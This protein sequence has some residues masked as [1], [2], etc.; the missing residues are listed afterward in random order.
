MV[1]E[2]TQFI[3]DIVSNLRLQSFFQATDSDYLRKLHFLLILNTNLKITPL[4]ESDCNVGHVVGAIPGI[5]RR[6]YFLMTYRYNLLEFMNEVIE[7]GPFIMV[8][9]LLEVVREE[10]KFLPSH[11]R[12]NLLNAILQAV[13]IRIRK[14]DS[15]TAA[16]KI[17]EHFQMLLLHF[18]KPESDLEETSEQAH[19]EIVN[20]GYKF[21]SLISLLYEMTKIVYDQASKRESYPLYEIKVPDSLENLSAESGLKSK[22]Q[23]MQEC[24]DNV[25]YKSREL[26]EELNLNMFLIWYEIKVDERNLQSLIGE[27][28]YFL[29][30]LLEEKLQN[31][32]LPASTGELISMLQTIAVKPAVCDTNAEYLKKSI[33]KNDIFNNELLELVECYLKDSFFDP[34]VSI[35]FLRKFFDERSRSNIDHERV[36]KI[37]E[38]VM[39]KLD[40]RDI[41]A[42]L[43]DFLITN[44]PNH[45]LVKNGND[46]NYLMKQISVLYTNSGIEGE[47][48]EKAF[49]EKEE[50]RV[51]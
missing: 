4:L 2:N 22:S 10:I 34:E 26:M 5:S 32:L 35:H 3:D 18:K 36:R 15:D 51:R 44:G 7:F 1:S 16:N 41:S 12:F 39:R 42:L 47:E 49:I 40:V 24:Y 11:D 25:L 29:C 9:E 30:R 50:E 17:A 37:I 45:F 48:Q 23:A 28:V 19:E 8:L 13:S 38:L 46:F 6:L 21:S 33:A 43:N 20:E 14:S 27:K 31:N